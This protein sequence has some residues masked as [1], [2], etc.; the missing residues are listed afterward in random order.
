MSAQYQ[1]AANGT[2]MGTY[3]GATERDAIAAYVKDAGY[4]D[5]A[6]AAKTLGQSVEEFLDDIAVTK[7]SE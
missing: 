6:I 3:S 7:I 4:A 1:I 5:V 2:D